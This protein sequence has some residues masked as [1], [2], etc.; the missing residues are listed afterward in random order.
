MTD[1]E[2]PRKDKEH[3]ESGALTHRDQRNLINQ[4][5]T[6]MSPEKR[7]ELMDKAAEEALALHKDAA[8]R[9]VVSNAAFQDIDKHVDTVDRLKTTKTLSTHKVTTDSET[10]SG[11][12]R[13]ESR[14]GPGCFV[15]SVAFGDP[16]AEQVVYL[17]HFRDDILA[18]GSTGRRFVG[19]YYTQG[20]KM[21]GLIQKRP[22]LR[23]VTRTC[24]SGLV[25]F[26]RRLIPLRKHQQVAPRL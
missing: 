6:S 18:R 16:N 5:L 7:Q 14:T 19:W 12:M 9:T 8:R 24:L 23:L 15:A 25:R 13:I 21:A 17:R 20:P 3:G 26:L 11:R 4:A 22:V 1:N 10:G 2:D